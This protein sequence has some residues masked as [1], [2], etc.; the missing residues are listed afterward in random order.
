MTVLERAD[1]IARGGYARVIVPVDFSPLSWRVL[2]LARAVAAKFDAELV[3]VHVD[4]ASPW[5]EADDGNRL[6]LSAS[7]FGQRLDVE[8][9]AAADAGSGIE[10]FV[11]RSPGPLLAMST[12]GHT[13]VGEMTFGSVCEEVL[14]RVDAPVL[15][16]GPEF[17]MVR[18]SDIRRLVVC[19]DAS[20]DSTAVVPDA[21]AWAERLDAPIELMTVLP[22][23]PGTDLTAE[24]DAVAAVQRLATELATRDDRVSSLVLHGGRPGFEIVR[25]ADAAPGTLIV[26]AT[27]ARPAVARTFLGGVAMHV[28]RHTTTGLLLRRRSGHE[29]PA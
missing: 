5:R 21:V 25:Y 10:K 8:V 16:V 13:G 19:I 12:H 26:M 2:P 28:A 20:S 29:S 24:H 4:T 6:A 17:D 9:V 11:R 15:A 1:A 22:G 7:P 23:M 3:P 18:H 27:H 14:R